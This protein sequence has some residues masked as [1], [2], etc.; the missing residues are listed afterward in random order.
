MEEKLGRGLAA[1]FG[2]S[3]GNAEKVELTSEVSIDLL[4]PNPNQPRRSFED[5]K[6]SELSSS[7]SF[8]GVLQPIVVRQKDDRYEIIAGER[9]WKAARMA[10]LTTVPIH[11]I[12]CTDGDLLALSLIENI[13]RDDLNPIDEASA[14]QKLIDDCAC[15]QEELG[16]IIGK[17]RSHVGNMLRLLYLPEEVQDFVR[18]GELTVGHARCLI[19]LE[20]ATE[21]ARL[22]IDRALNVRQ[23][24][25]VIKARKREVGKIGENYKN[26]TKLDG[27]ISSA[28]HEADDIARRIASTIKIDTKLKITRNGG[29]LTL[30]CKSCEEL[31]DLVE[32]LMSLER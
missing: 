24:E 23:L 9:R 5:D 18:S 17:S 8:H 10:G 31:E 30:T 19:G 3:A 21:V 28:D 12:G 27:T 25:N 16:S 22:A 2:D 15:T 7:I 1:L 20:D 4:D 13:Q 6:L 29:V 32:K 11:V 26:Q 14:I